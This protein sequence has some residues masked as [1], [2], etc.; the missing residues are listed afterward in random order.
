MGCDLRPS[1]DEGVPDFVDKMHSS[2]VRL[3]ERQMRRRREEEDEV[4]E[5]TTTEGQKMAM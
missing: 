2:A 1:V 5:E 3:H 4:D